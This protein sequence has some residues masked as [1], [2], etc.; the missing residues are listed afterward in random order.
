MFSRPSARVL[1][2]IVVLPFALAAVAF[3]VHLSSGYD[4]L[5]SQT[6]V[7]DLSR[8]PGV[9]PFF[10]KGHTLEVLDPSQQGAHARKSQSI[11]PETTGPIVGIS[12]TTAA[13]AEQVVPWVHYHRGLGVSHF[14]I[15]GSGKAML[16][17]H[18]DLIEAEEGVHFIK[19]TPELIAKQNESRILNEWWLAPY[20]N[21]PCNYLL[22]VHQNLNLEMGI[23]MARDN[24]VEWLFHIDTD[25]LVYPAGSPTFS[26]QRMLADIPSDVDNVVFANYEA[27]AERDDVQEP[28]TEVTL[29]KKNYDHVLRDQYFANYRDVAK[30]NPNYYL[31]YANGKSVARIKEGLRP[32]GAHRF[33]NYIKQPKE[34]QHDEAAILHYVYTKFS[35]LTT[36]KNRC[37]C[38][39]VKEEAEKCFIL[40]FDRQAFLK[41][42]LE[43]EAELFKWYQEHVV[44]SD[45][46]V[47]RKLITS[48]LFDRMYEPQIVI[49]NSMER[50]RALRV[51]EAAANAAELL[52]SNSL[53]QPNA[54][55]TS[56]LSTQM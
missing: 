32:N 14:F 36:R 22:S 40:E 35:D 1:R 54:S 31:T 56:S 29:F 27:L 7:G 49:K 9:K 46:K 6:K 43:S 38:K 5:E 48:G 33:H 47:V 39:P 13:G 3:A 45:P 2:V 8:L 52:P 12:T 25:E 21:K 50:T 26:I 37:G 28:F 15:F 18:A 53:M 24:K 51:A 4:P 30:G 16:P 11:L 23:Q 34:V 19:R 42:S 10:H 17:E 20:M 44:F 41:A 55:Q